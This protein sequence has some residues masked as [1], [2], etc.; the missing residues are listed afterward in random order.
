MSLTRFVLVPKI[1]RSKITLSQQYTS[2]KKYILETTVFEKT[3]G[4]LG[5]R[6]GIQN[7][8]SNLGLTPDKASAPQDILYELGKLNL[9]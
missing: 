2:R 9:L 6:T 4:H 1:W 5:G 7:F 3:K 8:A